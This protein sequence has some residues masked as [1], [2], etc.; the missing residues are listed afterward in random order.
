MKTTTLSKRDIDMLPGDEGFKDLVWEIVSLHSRK[1]QDYGTNTDPF[2]NVRA[3][4]D[5]GVS[6]W[7][8]ALIRMNDKVTRLKNFAERGQLANESAEDSMMDIAVYALIACLLY[9][10]ESLGVAETKPAFPEA[11]YQAE[12]DGYPLRD[13]SD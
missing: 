2:A 8:G 10:E 13:F 6:A 1:Q 11:K 7:V 9:R 4:Q 3:S 5:F 12:D